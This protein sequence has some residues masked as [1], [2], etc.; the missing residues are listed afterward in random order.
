MPS[1]EL[2]AANWLLLVIRNQCD[3]LCD[4]C[5]VKEVDC[6]AFAPAVLD[7][8]QK[9]GRVETISLLCAAISQIKERAIAFDRVFLYYKSRLA[10][11]N[12]I[13]SK[14]RRKVNLE[15]EYGKVLSVLCIDYDKFAE[16]KD[17]LPFYKNIRKDGV[18]LWQAA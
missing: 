5:F 15:L 14:S 4:L 11:S 6:H 2:D 10:F 7:L 9:F 16:W 12:R 18:V 8:K 17:V 3:G 1:V 13:V